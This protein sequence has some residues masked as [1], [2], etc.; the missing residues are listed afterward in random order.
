MLLVLKLGHVHLFLAKQAL[1]PQVLSKN[2][3]RPYIYD[4]LRD[5][6]HPES[7]HRIR[8]DITR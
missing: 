5:T 8:P 6:L 4:L 1:H 3:A 2:A 7:L